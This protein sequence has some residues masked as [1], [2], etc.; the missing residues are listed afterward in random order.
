MSAQA[1][2][3]A[4]LNLEDDADRHNFLAFLASGREIQD[5]RSDRPEAVIEGTS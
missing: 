5:L 4:F 2:H 3:P 1:L